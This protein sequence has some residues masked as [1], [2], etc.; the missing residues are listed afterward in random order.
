MKLFQ[1]LLICFPLATCETTSDKS[2]IK[3]GLFIPGD[4]GGFAES[5]S[6]LPMADVARQQINMSPKY[7]G[8]YKLETDWFNTKADSG[9]AIQELFTFIGTKDQRDYVGIVGP[10]FTD[11]T[12]Y[13]SELAPFFNYVSV[14]PTASSSSLSQGSNKSNEEDISGER[15]YIYRNSLR[16]HPVETDMYKAVFQLAGKCGWDKIHILSGE[17]QNDMNEFRSSVIKVFTDE[18]KFLYRYSFTSSNKESIRNAIYELKKSNARII[19]ANFDEDDAYDVFCE[20]YKADFL[21]ES[22]EFKGKRV[23][24]LPSS[25]KNNWV[26]QEVNKKLSNGTCSKRDIVQAVGT[27]L[28]PQFQWNTTRLDRKMDTDYYFT[29]T[30]EEYSDLFYKEYADECRAC[31]IEEKAGSLMYDSV[32]TFAMGLHKFLYHFDIEKGQINESHNNT[33]P[34]RDVLLQELLRRRGSRSS[35]LMAAMLQLS[36]EGASGRIEFDNKLD[37]TCRSGFKVK[38]QQLRVLDCGN[39]TSDQCDVELVDVCAGEDRLDCEM[40]SM[41]DTSIY[42]KLVPTCSNSTEFQCRCPVDSPI[43]EKMDQIIIGIPL[44]SLIFFTVTSLMG[45]LLAITFLV[46]NIV[47]MKERVIKMS[48][49]IINNIIL[50]GAVLLYSYVPLLALMMGIND[51]SILDENHLIK[52]CSVKL[53]NWVFFIGFTTTFGALFAKTWRVYAIFTSKQPRNMILS[54]LK[55]MIL[56]GI[57]LSVDVILLGI[58]EYLNR[59]KW[60]FQSAKSTLNV[61]NYHLLDDTPDVHGLVMCEFDPDST[62][63]LYETPWLITV[64]IVYKGLLL[65]FGAFIAFQ[66]RNI[67]IPALNDSKYIGISIYTIVVV[68]TIAGP[69]SF[70]LQSQPELLFGIQAAGIIFTTTIMICLVFIPK[71]YQLRYQPKEA[72]KNQ[73]VTRDWDSLAVSRRESEIQQVKNL[74]QELNKRDTVIKLLRENEQQT[75]TKSEGPCEGE[76]QVTQ[77]SL[78]NSV[79]EDCIQKTLYNSGYSSAV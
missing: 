1:V 57:L 45:I 76:G 56:I 37:R 3:L 59:Y 72:I 62:G 38:I 8:D 42:S 48:S 60:A 73:T 79:G 52:L 41:W 49:P 30:W 11:V 68:F 47:Y 69:V 5:K 20:A 78:F 54:D 14:S 74:R 33:G 21:S 9:K 67:T 31:Q 32:W 44:T 51:Y 61:N 26:A 29:D 7:L 6:L 17:G 16:L 12:K 71:A 15:K 63:R 66:T 22:L 75:I 46:F 18:M 23:W 27:Y 34:E 35:D 43:A 77:R 64:A 70:F 19:I 24:V 65:I 55:L 25:Y 50:L 13:I 28:T 2:V 4:I 10:V 58:N 40:E 36:F 53:Q 39:N